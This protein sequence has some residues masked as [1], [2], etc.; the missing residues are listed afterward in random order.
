MSQKSKHQLK[1]M[2]TN[3]ATKKEGNWLVKFFPIKKRTF[4]SLTLSGSRQPNM[5]NT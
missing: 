2:K 5:L 3:L 4:T 1:V